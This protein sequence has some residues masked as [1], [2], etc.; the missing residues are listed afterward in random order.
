MAERKTDAEHPKVAAVRKAASNLADAIAAAR[1]AGFAVT[2]P[3]R[4]E[5]LPGIIVS[6][7]GTI[8]E[9]GDDTLAGTKIEEVPVTS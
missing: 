6:E 4:A 1:K 9:D 8:V 5:E 7:T 3:G 2:L